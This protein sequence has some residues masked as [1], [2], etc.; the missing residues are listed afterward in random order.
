MRSFETI[1]S[2]ETFHPLWGFVDVNSAILQMPSSSKMIYNLERDVLDENVLMLVA[3][4]GFKLG[5][6][7]EVISENRNEKA[8][9][10]FG[11]YLVSALSCIHFKSV[12]REIVNKEIFELLESQMSSSELFDSSREKYE[13]VVENLI[14]YSLRNSSVSLYKFSPD[15]NLNTIMPDGSGPFDFFYSFIGLEIIKAFSEEYLS[16]TIFKLGRD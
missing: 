13:N 15:K 4:S 2:C 3:N 5:V 11:N 1:F 6:K 10:T 8:N 14:S 12:S 16:V 9:L 7:S